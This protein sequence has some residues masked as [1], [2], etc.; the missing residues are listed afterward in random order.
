[1]DQKVTHFPH[2]FTNKTLKD[3]MQQPWG[4]AL[5]LNLY[6]K[7]P[8][9]LPSLARSEN[10]YFAD[11]KIPMTFLMNERFTKGKVSHGKDTQCPIQ[12]AI[13]AEKCS[14]TEQSFVQASALDT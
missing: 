8:Q 14:D 7:S 2:S 10:I 4:K 12:D 13:C 1:M 3:T 9:V 5:F 11:L 6:K